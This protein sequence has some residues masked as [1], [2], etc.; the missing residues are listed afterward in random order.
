[1]SAFIKQITDL[2]RKIH[3]YRFFFD[4]QIIFHDYGISMQ[5]QAF[6]SAKL[7]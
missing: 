6:L 3:F 5:I 7:S 4:F 1:M 2:N